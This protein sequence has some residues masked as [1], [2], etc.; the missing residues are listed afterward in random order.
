MS[1]KNQGQ[2][3]KNQLKNALVL[4]GVGLQMGI[5]IYLFILLGKWL[6]SEYNNGDKLFVIFG[7]LLGV[8][9]SLYTVVKQLNRINS[10]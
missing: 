3:P 4:T 10:K 5:I 1:N 6:D 9:V 7:T 8:G 2:E